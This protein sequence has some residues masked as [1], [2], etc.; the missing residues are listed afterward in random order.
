MGEGG[1]RGKPKSRKVAPEKGKEAWSEKEE[2]SRARREKSEKR[3]KDSPQKKYAPPPSPQEESP[4][5][6]RAVLHKKR[7]EQLDLTAVRGIDEHPK[8]NATLPVKIR[9][10]YT[11]VFVFAAMA[12][13]LVIWEVDIL[14]REIV[15]KG[16]TQAAVSGF[17]MNGENIDGRIENTELQRLLKVGLLIC[18]TIQTGLYLRYHRLLTEYNTQRRG[19]REM[20]QER[21]S[22]RLG[23][24]FDVV[25]GMLHIPFFWDWS[26]EWDTFRSYS[27][28]DMPWR[29]DAPTGK[30]AVPYH[31]DMASMFLVLPF[32]VALIPRLVLY[33]SELWTE[34]AALASIA[35]VEVSVGVAIRAGFTRSPGRYLFFLLAF[36]FVTCSII[37]SNCERLVTPMYGSQ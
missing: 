15:K 36:P 23:L 2:R 30:F 16:Y 5:G 22:R 4:R 32:N 29:Y 3:E 35:N 11:W 1:E 26:F 12:V 28:G 8:Q 18:V 21:W 24:A 19:Q 6:E 34:G 9:N 14:T 17:V 13:F 20:D 7:G 31:I 10:A 37:F 27:E 25:L 33:H